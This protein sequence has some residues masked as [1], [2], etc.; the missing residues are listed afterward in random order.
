MTYQ[1]L[2]LL[3]LPYEVLDRIIF[4][5]EAKDIIKLL[6]TSRELQLLLRHSYHII[7]DNVESLSRNIPTE[8]YTKVEDA[9][10]DK[11]LW[12]FKG[13]LLLEIHDIRKS[14]YQ[15]RSLIDAL[16]Y[17]CSCKITKHLNQPLLGDS[18]FF[19]IV[20]RAATR[21][22]IIKSID[23]PE[24]TSFQLHH[25]VWDLSLFNIPKVA[26]LLLS[27]CVTTNYEQNK[28]VLP[29]LVN[30]YIDQKVNKIFDSIELPQNVSMFGV[31]SKDAVIENLSSRK[32]E[33]WRIQSSKFTAI[34]NCDLP[35]LKEFRML[36]SQIDQLSGFHAKNLT[37]L[38]IISKDAHLLWKNVTLESLVHLQIACSSLSEDFENVSC[39]NLEIVELR[40]YNQPMSDTNDEDYVNPF[41]FL[42]QAQDLRVF[43]GCIHILES[44][45]FEKLES[46][47]FCGNFDYNLTQKT[48]TPKLQTLII[49]NNSKIKQLPQLSSH[50]L[51]SVQL[52]AC[53]FI[54]EDGVRIA[55][56]NLKYLECEG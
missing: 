21:K 29:N 47:Y 15:F 31:S 25:S 4:Y 39:P 26:T 43:D 11:F 37:T 44:L 5:L 10:F 50:D 18:K 27:D 2:E 1:N 23:L 34:K 46:L 41:S 48:K 54:Q 20:Y 16:P 7:T 24:S 42:Q 17:G 53:P 38:C 49:H 52:K 28:R 45:V 32:L 33:D 51:S 55:Y 14:S 19:D 35:S 13:T 40:L 12:M 3:S 9:D 6:G 36:D 56:P 22:K 30:L 8:F